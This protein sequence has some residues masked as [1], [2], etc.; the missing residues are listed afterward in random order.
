MQSRERY[1]PA[2]QDCEAECT[3]PTGINMGY[4]AV[5]AWVLDHEVSA[6]RQYFLRGEAT[7]QERW[8]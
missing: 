7:F 6:D 5:R 2:D 8:H 4:A 3:P 1:T